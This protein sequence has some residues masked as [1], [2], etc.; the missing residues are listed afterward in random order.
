MIALLLTSLL[1]LPSYRQRNYVTTCLLF[2]IF[3]PVV[4]RLSKLYFNHPRPLTWFSDQ[5]VHTVSW[6]DNLYWQS[7]PSGHT[8]GAFGFF[9]LLSLYLPSGRKPWS[10][11][12][13]LLALACGYSRIY[14]GQHF[15]LDVYAGSIAG[16]I[17]AFLVY[18]TGQLIA[19]PSAIKH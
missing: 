14:L 9:L 7:F 12:F 1:L 13:F 6:L 19:R 15:F 3:F 8:F 10:L 5:P 11:F 16:T 4:I 18:L 2:G 17:L